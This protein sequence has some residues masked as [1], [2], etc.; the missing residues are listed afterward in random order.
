MPLVTTG[1]F[2]HLEPDILVWEV[3][4]A[5]GIITTNKPSGGDGIPAELL[6]ILKDGAV[7]VLCSIFQQIW[8]ILTVAT[9]QKMKVFN[10]VSEKASAKECSNYCTIV[11]ISH[12]S[13][14][15]LKILLPRLQGYM[16]WKVQLY[17]LHFKEAE[18]TNQIASVHW[19]MRKAGNSRKYIYFCFID[20]A[21]TFDC[22]DHNKL[23]KIIKG[24]GVLDHLTYLLRNLYVGQEATVITRHGTMDWFKIGEEVRKG[25]ISSSCLFNFYV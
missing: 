3:N 19:I 13:K 8:N 9:G 24:T 21:K 25:C 16:N 7:N 12:A 17:K 2:N 10:P 1:V 4:W 6:K 11:L 23:W 18:E 22:V 20:Y 15:V 14:V 5:L